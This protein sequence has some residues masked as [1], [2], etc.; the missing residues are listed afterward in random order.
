[1]EMQRISIDADEL[2]L[3]D[4]TSEFDKKYMLEDKKVFKNS[5]ED[6]ITLNT[7]MPQRKNKQIIYKKRYC[8]PKDNAL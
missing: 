4:F 8:L 5:S 1:M 3:T 7:N 2:M 6:K